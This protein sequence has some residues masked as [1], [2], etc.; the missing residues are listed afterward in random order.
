VT[1]D[2]RIFQFA[3]RIEHLEN[4]RIIRSA[5]ASMSIN[6]RHFVESK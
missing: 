6:I 3:D 2:P 5:E 4:G 1:H